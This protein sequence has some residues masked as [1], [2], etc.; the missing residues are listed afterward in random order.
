ML[1]GNEVLKQYVWT[2][3]FM[4]QTLLGNY[5]MVPIMQ[6]IF[7]IQARHCI[8]LVN[9]VTDL[10]DIRATITVALG[11]VEDSN[12]LKL[13]CLQQVFQATACSLTQACPSTGIRSAFY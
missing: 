1:T 9:I 7:N 12:T 5:Q 8:C 13:I 3:V 10:P 6:V 2:S 11:R 4:V